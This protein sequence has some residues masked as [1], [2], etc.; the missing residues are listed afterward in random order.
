MYT[1]GNASLNDDINNNIY[2]N[3]ADDIA[4]L[5]IFESI[6]APS[7]AYDACIRYD[8]VAIAMC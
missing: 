4:R 3:S 8:P 7:A 6:R 5:H 1:F 2:N